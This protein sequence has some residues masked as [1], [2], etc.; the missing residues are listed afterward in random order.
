MFTHSLQQGP[1]AAAIK[2]P[3]EFFPFKVSSKDVAIKPDN[4]S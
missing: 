3:A 4:D 2:D 1:I